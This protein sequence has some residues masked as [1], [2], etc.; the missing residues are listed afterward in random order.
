MNR[1]YIYNAVVVFCYII[2]N[3]EVLLIKRN[4]PPDADKY[5][6]IGGK[7]ERG[8]DLMA[9]CKR[10]VF[11]ETGLILKTIQFRG[12]VNIMIEESDFETLAFYFKSEE[13]SGDLVSTAE[14]NVQW[15]NIDDSFKKAGMSDFYLRISPFVFKEGK[16]FLGSINLNEEEEIQS[17]NIV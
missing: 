13:F 3:N 9:A 8:E 5:T 10:E 12:A 7:K 4:M 15:C 6:V 2:K 14:G 17:V 16:A 11:E 1:D